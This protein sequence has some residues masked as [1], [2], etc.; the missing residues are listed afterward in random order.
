MR[1]GT[2]R[3]VMVGIIIYTFIIPTNDLALIAATKP[4]KSPQPQTQQ[5]PQQPTVPTSSQGI[6]VSVHNVAVDAIVTDDNG[7]YLKDLKKENFRILEDG[8]PQEIVS[9][10]KGDAPMT[11]VMLLE[12]S[13][14]FQSFTS[15]TARYWGPVFLRTLRPNDWV[16][17]EDF[18]MKTRVDVDFTHNPNEILDGLRR[19][20]FPDFKESN[21]RDA[22]LETLDRLKDVKGKK[23]ILL[24]ATGYDT[25]SKHSLDQTLKELKQ[26]DVTIFSVGLGQ[27]LVYEWTE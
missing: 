20:V 1:L 2:F 22:V 15:Y 25:F 13:E 26:T 9:F 27:Q 11:I 10:G 18:S 21:L 5:A 4:V 16:A 6:T 17:L 12:F 24:M 3:A 7:A 23:A 19:L 8:K 14:L